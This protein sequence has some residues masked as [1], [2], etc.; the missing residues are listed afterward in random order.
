M[1]AQI[2]T[3]YAKANPSLS[4]PFTQRSRPAGNV[5]SRQD[6]FL[7]DDTTDGKWILKS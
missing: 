3:A 5:P 7:A 1:L 6:T 2:E 4:Q